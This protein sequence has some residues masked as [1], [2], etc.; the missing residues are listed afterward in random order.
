MLI[1]LQ[2]LHTHVQPDITCYTHTT[3]RIWNEHAC[4]GLVQGANTCTTLLPDSCSPP[5]LLYIQAGNCLS[6]ND[7]HKIKVAAEKVNVGRAV[8]ELA[9]LVKKRGKTCH[10]RFFAALSHT[11]AYSP[12]PGSCLSH[13]GPQLTWYRQHPGRPGVSRSH[14]LCYSDCLRNGKLTASTVV[15]TWIM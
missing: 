14:L 9:R 15:H 12:F 3:H 6:E 5:P 10:E 8:H 4:H 7:I 11:Y 2:L 13:S 1:Q